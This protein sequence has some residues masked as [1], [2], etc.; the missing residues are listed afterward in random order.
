MS[1]NNEYRFGSLPTTKLPRSVFKMKKNWKGTFNAGQ[2]IPFYVNQ[3]VVPSSS[4]KIKQSIVCR[5]LTPIYPT[6]DDLVLDVYFFADSWRRNWD[7]F[8]KFMGENT[9]GAWVQTADLEV[10]QIQVPSTATGNG[11]PAIKS[12]WDYM[13]LAT[14]VKGD[15]ISVSALPFR[16]YCEVYNYFFRNQNLIAP[17]QTPK[18][19]SNANYSLAAYHGGTPLKASKLP[20]YFTTALP[21]PQKAPNGAVTI[22]L[23]SKAKVWGDGMGIIYTYDSDPINNPNYA[24]SEQMKATNSGGYEQANIRVAPGGGNNNMSYPTGTLETDTIQFAS[25]RIRG[26][27]TKEQSEAAYNTNGLIAN[28][29]LYADLSEATAATL[30]A[31][32]LKVQTQMIYERDGMYGTR[33]FDEILYGHFGTTSGA[34]KFEKPQYIGGKR[35][36]LQMNQV[37]ATADTANNVLG[38]TGAFSLTADVDYMVNQSFTEHMILMGIFVIR[39]LT[40]TSQQAIPR[41]WSIKKRLDMWWHEYDHLGNQPI[42]NKEIYADGSSTDNEVFG[43]QER[44]AEYRYE[45][46][47]ICGEFKSTGPTPLDSWHYGDLYNSLPTL[48]KQW[49]EETDQNI[50]R[51]LAVQNHDQFMVDTTLYIKATLPLPV[52]GTPMLMDHF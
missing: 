12:L 21:E 9:S 51:T 22:P 39:Q 25:K 28:S 27:L 15:S 5:M 1:L 38:A 43:Y 50:A 17:I 42:Y 41:Q 29:G 11:V 6:M 46:N 45:D 4:Y 32:R 44:F 24:N 2:I 40:H 20:S 49:I 34:A 26:L 13:G 7:N 30:N 33:Y 16:M 8:K 14:G 19:D 35:I 10:P 3:L 23:G 37:A 18:G 52:F 48:S 47:V 36:P 31:L